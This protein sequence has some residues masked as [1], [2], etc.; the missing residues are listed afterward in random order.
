MLYNQSE[1]PWELYLRI[2]H[3]VH[4][5]DMTVIEVCCGTSPASRAAYLLGI[6]SISL[7]IRENQVDNSISILNTFLAD[8]GK[9]TPVFVFKHFFCK[10]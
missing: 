1:K 10:P 6:S 4:Q 9:A 7:D 3:L 8:F 5:P 2:M